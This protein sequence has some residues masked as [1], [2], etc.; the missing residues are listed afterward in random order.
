MAHLD[1]SGITRFVTDLKDRF[2]TLVSGA[3]PIAQGGTGATTAAGAVVNIVD[4]QAIEPTSVAATGEVTGKNGTVTHKLSDKAN[5]A[6]IAPIEGTTAKTNHVLGDYFMLGGN[7]RKATTTIATG[8]AIGDSNSVQTDV[9]GLFVNV[10]NN[11]M[12]FRGPATGDY[13]D[14]K[15]V[16]M[17]DVAGGMTANKPEASS[18]L[19]GMLI[20]YP[21]AF[22]SGVATLVLQLYFATSSKAF[23]RIYGNVSGWTP[24]RQLATA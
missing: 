18:S 22:T 19:S 7:L 11:A 21:N 16:G 2:A 10:W 23:F 14:Y 3:V 4:G 15:A 13:N 20:V 24:W 12:I 8:E 1:A 5:G 17:Y 9:N 6:A